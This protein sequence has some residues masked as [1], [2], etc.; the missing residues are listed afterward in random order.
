[1]Y[2]INTIDK[3][4]KVKLYEYHQ[5][6]KSSDYNKIVS[7]LNEVV[8][9]YQAKVNT[10]S[11]IKSLY[12]DVLSKIENIIKNSLNMPKKY[13]QPMQE[14]KITIPGKGNSKIEIEIKK[15]PQ[16]PHKGK[17]K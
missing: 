5:I 3:Q 17:K 12:T 8:G 14:K 9:L 4:I 16:Q 15:I 2:Q 6:A 13:V 11:E 7:L 10:I 1:M